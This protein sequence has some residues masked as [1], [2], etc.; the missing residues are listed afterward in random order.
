MVLSFPLSVVSGCVLRPLSSNNSTR[1]VPRALSRRRSPERCNASTRNELHDARAR[2]RRAVGTRKTPCS[3]CGSSFETRRRWRFGSPGQAADRG[4]ARSPWVY[5]DAIVA[6][7]RELENR[8]AAAGARHRRAGGFLAQGFLGRLTR[9]SRLRVVS[10]RKD[11]SSSAALAAQRVAEAAIA[12]RGRPRAATPGDRRLIGSATGEGDR[13]AGRRHRSLRRRRGRAASTPTPLRVA[14]S[15]Q[16]PTRSSP[17]SPR[18]AFGRWRSTC[19]RGGDGPSPS[20]ARRGA[21][22][23][24]ASPPRRRARPIASSSPSA[25]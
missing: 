18:E 24:R 1:S 16:P 5:R 3:R 8:L 7:P 4:A 21:V 17:R 19:G 22:E 25:G 14:R 23:G 11:R 6:P 13:R 15:R 10:R 20:G 2:C 12:R 9:R